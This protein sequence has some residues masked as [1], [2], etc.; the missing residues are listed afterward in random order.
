VHHCIGIGQGIWSLAD[1]RLTTPDDTLKHPSGKTETLE[2][3]C[4]LC[5]HY[6]SSGTTLLAA[7]SLK[8]FV[9]PVELKSHRAPTCERTASRWH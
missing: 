3:L 9:V 7:G 5:M 4:L 8:A 2:W 6:V 1:Y